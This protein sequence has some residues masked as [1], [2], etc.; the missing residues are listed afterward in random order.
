LIVSEGFDPAFYGNFSSDGFCAEE[1][2][3]FYTFHA[4]AKEVSFWMLRK[5]RYVFEKEPQK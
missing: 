2:G 5:T 4:I 3:D 1:F